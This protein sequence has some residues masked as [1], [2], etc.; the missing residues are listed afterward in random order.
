MRDGLND[1]EKSVQEAAGGMLKAWLNACK[2][3]P[4]QLLNSGRSTMVEDR[5]ALLSA[6]VRFLNLFDLSGPGRQ[7][8]H[9]ALL[10]F[11]TAI[12]ELSDLISFHGVCK[13][14]RGP[15]ICLLS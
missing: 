1:R 15:F 10:Y 8:S 5:G 12:P 3:D 2:G 14:S 4:E 7:V 6:T 11:F 13:S 9:D